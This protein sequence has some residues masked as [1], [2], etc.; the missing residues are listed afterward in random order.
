MAYISFYDKVVS[1]PRARQT[2]KESNSTQKTSKPKGRK[3]G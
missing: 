2:A 1:M 3:K